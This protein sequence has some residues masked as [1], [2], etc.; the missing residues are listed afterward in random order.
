MLSAP[1]KELLEGLTAWHSAAN[2]GHPELGSE[3][4]VVRVHPETGRR[5]LFVNRS[6]TSHVLQM[7]RQ[8]SDA[9][10]QF[11]FGWSE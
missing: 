2:F 3:H 8:E 6:F 5:S 1:M 7:R 9:L 4:P 10:L 11:F